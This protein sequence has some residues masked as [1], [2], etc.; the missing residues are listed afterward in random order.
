[1]NHL[2]LANLDRDTL[3]G[4]LELYPGAGAPGAARQLQGI[5]AVATRAVTALVPGD[6][7]RHPARG[8]EVALTLDEDCFQGGSPLLFAAVLERLFAQWC[9][10]HGFVRLRAFSRR[11]GC[12]LGQWP[13]RMEV[14]E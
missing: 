4:M 9:P 3:Q 1:M 12:E 8:I 5:A 14:A 13:L 10:E 11:H 2:G 6:H 7:Q